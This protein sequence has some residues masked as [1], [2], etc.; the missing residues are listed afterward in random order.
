MFNRFEFG[1]NPCARFRCTLSNADGDLGGPVDKERKTSQAI[2]VELKH[3]K[4]VKILYLSF[5]ILLISFKTKAG[6]LA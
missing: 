4:E 6:G 1:L 3:Y 2:R 5:Y